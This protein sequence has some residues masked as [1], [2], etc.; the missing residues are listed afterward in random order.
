[1]SR[2]WKEGGNMRSTNTKRR[3]LDEGLR[4]F[5]EKGYKAVSMEQIA[6]AVGVRAPSL[7]KHYP[8]KEAIFRAIL[9]EMKQRHLENMR[10]MQMR[11]REA[12]DV[13]MFLRIGEE[14][15][16]ELGKHL[17]LYYLHDDAFSNFRKIL[18][19]GQYADREI[20]ALLVQ[21]CMAGPLAYNEQL[22]G[23]MMG[24]GA[25]IQSSPKVMALHF[26]API[27]MLLLI[28]D[29]TPSLEAQSLQTL[30][31]HIRQFNRLYG[32]VMEKPNEQE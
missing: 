8:G 23:L 30:E 24:A 14:E 12:Q 19:L 3:I 21:E 18:T 5:A 9:A 6:A 11:G 1:M 4:L 25:F 27:Y 10:A 26:Y 17:F 20:A 16:V 13:G 29:V 7:Y 32:N 15:L 2:N 31:D 22:F 28:C